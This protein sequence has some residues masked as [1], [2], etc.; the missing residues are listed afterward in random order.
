MNAHPH[1][2]A[3]VQA[4]AER[5]ACKKLPDD[6]V[7]IDR[8]G[9][10]LAYYRKPYAMEPKW[11]DLGP[12]GKLVQEF[13]TRETTATH[14]DNARRMATVAPTILLSSGRYF[15]FQNPEPLTIDEVAHALANICRFSGNCREFYSVAQ[16]C[17]LVSRLLPPHLAMQG[18]L[19]EVGEAVMGDMA[20]PLKR[21][22]PEFKALEHRVEA[23]ILAGFGLPATLDPLV[24]R[25]D[26]VALRT[27][28]RDLM[29]KEGGLWTCLDGIEPHEEIIRPLYPHAA[30]ELF[31][32]RFHQLQAAAA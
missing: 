21:L 13:G 1:T 29:R 32:W 4:A 24:K 27:E 17:V 19:H 25:A 31:L 30:R 9:G 16:H 6:C 7:R 8:Q 10:V 12:A 11:H 3:E 5:L 28:Q 20:G 2:F 14:E 26:L 15:D 23:V 22:F 18:L